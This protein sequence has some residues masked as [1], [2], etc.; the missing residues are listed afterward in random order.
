MKQPKPKKCRVCKTE[1]QPRN[2]L[3]VVCSPKCAVALQ[4]QKDEQRLRRQ[5]KVALEAFKTRGDYVKE[6]QV[7]VNAFIRIRDAG[8]PCISCGA[9]DTPDLVGGGRDA[10]HYISRGARPELRFNTFNIH[11]QCKRCNRYL[12]GNVAN[13]RLG[14]ID[15]LGL[16]VVERLESDHAPKHYSISDLKRVKSIFSKRARLYKKRFR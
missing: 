13:M 11:G 5:K 1:Y 2:S 14:I 6:A 10:G 12:S 16:E 9:P 7:A 4:K 8:K 15:R 3:Q